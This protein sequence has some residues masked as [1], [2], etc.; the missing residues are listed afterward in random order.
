MGQKNENGPRVVKKCHG[1][2]G[3]EGNGAEEKNKGPGVEKMG[4]D[5]AG[6][7]GAARSMGHKS[8]PG[9]RRLR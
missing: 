3:A 9:S 2:K 7:P 4:A 8:W 1:I 6:D 5:A